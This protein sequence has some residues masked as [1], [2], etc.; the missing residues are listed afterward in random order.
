MK[1][2]KFLLP[3]FTIAAILSLGLA[4]CNGGNEGGGQ[5]NPSS[6]QGE[7][8]KQEKI[9]ISAAGDKKN[10]ILGETVQLTASVDG[11]TW[12]SKN[13]EIATVDA[14]GL[15]TSVAVGSASITASKE[16][17]KDGSITIK[18]DL[19]NIIVTAASE[20]TLLAGQTVQLSADQEGVSWE[21]SDATIASVDNK[22]LV[23]AVK[24][25]TVQITASKQG[26]NP[27]KITINVVRPAAN[28]KFDFTVDADH[29]SADGWWELPSTGGFSFAMQTVN[30]WN[31]ISQAASWGQ[32]TEEPAET[33]VGGFGTGDKETIKFSSNKAVKA[34]FV[35]NIGNSDEVTLKDKMAI[36]VNDNNVDLTDVVLAAN[37]GDWGN[38][39]AF[40][41]LSLGE[42]DIKNGE[43]TIQFEILDDNNLF[44]NELTLYAGD[45]TITVVA[46]AAKQ[47]ITVAET[48]LE[49]IVEETV[50]IQ[51]EITGLSYASVDETIATVNDSGVVTGVK[52]GKTNITV[53]KDGMYSVRVEITVNPK[54]V[55]G[56]ILIEAEDG[57]EVT[58]DWNSGG[59]MKQTDGGGWGGSSD[60]HSGG[61]YVTYFSMGGGDVDLT[62]TI[63]FNAPENAKMILSVVGSAPVSYGGE[64]APY[65]FK[66]S[67]ELSINE[68]VLT[69]DEQAFPA[70]EGYTATMV[71]IVLGEVDVKSGE[72][73]LVFHTTGSAPSLDVFKLSVKA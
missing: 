70:P 46:P 9:T 53:K 5:E 10:L 16:G 39:L 2:N 13:P 33:F 42:L 71:E 73:T 64:A 14:N 23:T 47:Q 7:S 11:V 41:D 52:V 61:A 59:Y 72:N 57:E 35:L 24:F 63:K 51:S 40:N 36:K 8:G 49:V 19:Q 37:A 44:L 54:P 62:L 69:F 32:Q 29:Y 12:A 30:G 4:A 28:A 18:V 21:S 25:G 15:V 45:A 17:Y 60:V 43:N 55:A 65:V 26:F 38:S 6:Q 31:P 27:G 66:D 48:Q 67:A 3:I 1:K 68:N 22:G 56:Q 34:E 20:T 58:S 50:A